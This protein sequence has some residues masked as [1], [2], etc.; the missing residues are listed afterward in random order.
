MQ[1]TKGRMDEDIIAM[2]ISQPKTSIESENRKEEYHSFETRLGFVASEICN[3][4]Q[5]QLDGVEGS[6]ISTL[7]NLHRQP[8]FWR[9]NIAVS[10]PIIS[11]CC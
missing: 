7:L 5:T 10:V 2:K 9:N 3:P 6:E 8:S 1:P 4:E 11:L